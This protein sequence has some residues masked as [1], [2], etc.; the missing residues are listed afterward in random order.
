MS[1]PSADSIDQVEPSIGEIARRLAGTASVRRQVLPYALAISGMSIVRSLGE[2][3]I[4]LILGCD[5]HETNVLYSR[6]ARRK[7]FFSPY[8]SAAF[9][10]ELRFF[11]ESMGARSV[12]FS[13]DDRAILM[14][15][16]H[17]EELAPFFYFNY[18][19][20]DIVNQL[21]DKRQFASLACRLNLPVPF[22][23]MPTTFDDVAAMANQIPYP[24]VIKPA[25]RED[26]WHPDFAIK[27]GRYRKAIECGSSAEL[28]DFYQKIA[29]ISPHVI[30]QELI[31]GS[32]AQ[33]FSINMYY[34]SDGKLKAQFI[35]HK[36]RSYPIHAGI[37]CLMETVHSD[38]ILS[39]SAEIGSKLAMRGYCNIQFKRDERS[40]LL[41]SLEIHVRNSSWSYLG[42]ASGVNM[43]AI[44]YYDMIGQQYTG[45][46][47]PHAGIKF[48][49]LKRDLKA[50]REY[51]KTGEWTFGSWLRSLRGVRVNS[52]LSWVDPIP[53]FADFWF[54]LKRK[55]R[56]MLHRSSP[57]Q[58]DMPV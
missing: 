20:H 4:P 46:V 16:Q 52:T 42:T 3:R 49:D 14:F 51:R 35:A 26:W 54:S 10:R 55:M 7:V 19:P 44:G 32:D 50:L 11:G 47:S 48:L 30:V 41:K 28:L 38:E 56:K 40:G 37:G 53:F 43:A 5:I 33:M 57:S 13:D 34:S 23:A 39:L 2:A 8:L 1:R 36:H 27:V 24:C 22:T 6:F 45:S 21:L 15:S 17:R 25:H 58:D 9:V 12:F 29:Q 31:V 18:P